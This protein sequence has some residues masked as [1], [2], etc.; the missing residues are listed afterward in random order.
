MRN[1]N[2]LLV[3]VGNATR[4]LRP[5]PGRIVPALLAFAVICSWAAEAAHAIPTGCPGDYND[6][7]NCTDAADY[8]IWRKALF[9]QDTLINEGAT[10]G[11][12]DA[13]DYDVWRSN[14]GGVAVGAGSLA[15]PPLTITTPEPNT[16]LMAICVALLGASGRRRRA[17][18]G[19]RS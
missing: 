10:P 11:Y 8:V 1:S 14:F 16:L 15:A 4:F 7:G 19:G 12:V 6:D 5:R 3:A 17:V 13:A 9:T 18:V 2:R